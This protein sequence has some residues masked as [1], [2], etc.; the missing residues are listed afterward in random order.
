[1]ESLNVLIWAIAI[2]ILSPF[3]LTLLMML[4]V[5]ILFI[6]TM[7][8]AIIITVWEFVCKLFKNIK[9]SFKQ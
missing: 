1:M 7:I 2:A 8:G 4:G 9:K 6:L 5:A 3:I